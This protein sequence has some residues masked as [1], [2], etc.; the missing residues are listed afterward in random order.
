MRRK[1]LVDI[2]VIDDNLCSLECQFHENMV[3]YGSYC[4][5]KQSDPVELICSLDRC[6]RTDNCRNSE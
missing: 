3:A 2:D 1:A 4:Y 6:F 5:L